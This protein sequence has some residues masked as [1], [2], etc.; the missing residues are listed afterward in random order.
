MPQVLKKQGGS[1]TALA[2]LVQLFCGWTR[3]YFAVE[4]FSLPII[5]D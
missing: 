5:Q 2:W 3:N 1:E 4:D